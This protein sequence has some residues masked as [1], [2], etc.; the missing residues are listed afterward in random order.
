MATRIHFTGGDLAID[1]TESP[2]D[3]QKAITVGSRGAPFRVEHRQAGEAYVNPAAIAFWHQT[4]DPA[5][6]SS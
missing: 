1:V 4:P 6:P 2:D 3:V 5:P